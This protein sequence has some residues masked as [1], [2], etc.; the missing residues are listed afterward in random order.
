MNDAIYE[1]LQSA[2]SQDPSVL[3][4]AEQTL[5]EWET[6]PGFYATLFN[7]FST[8]SFALNVRWMA[9]LY[10]KNGVDKYWRKN[11]PGEISQDE[12]ELIRRGLI[13][14]FI[15]PVN[16]LAIQKAVLIAKIARFDCPKEWI[17]LLPTLL[18]VIQGNDSLA[19]HRALLTFHQVVKT[20]ASKRLAPDRNLFIELTSN[21]FNFILNFWNSNTEAFFILT[22]NGADVNQIQ[23]V[24]GKAH[25][26]LKILS[27]LVINGFAKPSQSQDAM[28]FLKTIFERAKSSLE[29]RSQLIRRNIQLELCDKFIIHLTKVLLGMVDYHP[30]CYIDFI[31][32]SLEFIY[33]YCFTEQ[34]RQVAFERFT[35]Q[36]LNL[37]KK[38][39]QTNDYKPAKIPEETGNVLTL[40]AYQSKQ[41]FF[42]E[43][44]LT[45]ICT[46]IVTHYFVLTS[47]DLDYWNNDPENFG[48]DDTG[49]SWKYSLRPCVETMFL[50][51][52]HRFK[53]ILSN[54]LVQLI[55]KH[56]HPADPNDL[57]GLLMKDAVYNAVGLA[58]FD[59]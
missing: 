14:S 56:H 11:A 22:Q 18:E 35:I 36:C 59:M 45:E 55:Q 34:G 4:P 52:L 46:K 39:L 3:K 5:K 7:V 29:C 26:T 9:V 21:V 2:S 32:S 42:S 41:E 58:G 12:K 38:I 49:E 47:E 50:A 54:V 16:Q 30:L 19:Q 51:L 8:Q 20:L 44:V 23:E 24:L 1:V 37:M 28:L 48:Y 40:K 31:P 10:L 33:Y 43:Q 15:E 17:S 57:S 25:L 13:V 53:D 27:K 6:Q